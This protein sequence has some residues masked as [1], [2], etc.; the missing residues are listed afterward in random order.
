MFS[1]FWRST[2]WWKILSGRWQTLRRF[3][4]QLGVGKVNYRDGVPKK[5]FKADSAK[6]VQLRETPHRRGG[7]VLCIEERTDTVEAMAEASSKGRLP[8][9]PC[10][11]ASCWITGCITGHYFL[12]CNFMRESSPRKWHRWGF[13]STIYRKRPGSDDLPS[14]TDAYGCHFAGC[15]TTSAISGRQSF[16]RCPVRN[17]FRDS[18]EI[19]TFP[20]SLDTNQSGKEGSVRGRKIGNFRFASRHGKRKSA[21]FSWSVANSPIAHIPPGLPTHVDCPSFSR[22]DREIDRARLRIGRHKRGCAAPRAF[23]NGTVPGST[24]RP[25]RRICQGKGCKL[26]EVMGRH[27]RWFQSTI[28]FGIKRKS[29]GWNGVCIGCIEESCAS[30]TRASC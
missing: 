27:C 22:A 9:C 29:T 24:N 5:P 8:R 7:L 19:G 12:A 26:S 13:Q 14:G 3:V 10:A 23:A 18:G 6:I 28:Q 2:F 25:A 16:R 1:C 15:S 4:L 20:G 11:N 30:H 17:W 21:R